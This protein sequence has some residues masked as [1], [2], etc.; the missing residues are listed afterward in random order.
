MGVHM[1]NMQKKSV[2]AKVMRGFSLIEILVVITLIGLIVGGIG[3]YVANNLAEGKES[4]ARTQIQ[5]VAKL[6]E[7]YNLRMNKYPSTAEG[8]EALV[9]PP[10]GRPIIESLPVDPW[11]NPYVYV[12][13]GVKSPGKY[14]LSSMGTDGVE[15]DDDIGNW[16]K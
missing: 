16:Q 11:G 3:V 5:E 14:D 9:N 10:R 1:E 8:L 7:M 4:I 15:S 12:Y 13:P 6:L 2:A